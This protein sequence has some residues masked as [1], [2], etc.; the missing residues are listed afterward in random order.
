MKK[1]AWGIMIMFCV[2]SA[3]ADK[4]TRLTKKGGL[5]TSPGGTVEITVPAGAVTKTAKISILPDYLNE[6]E[7][8]AYVIETSKEIELSHPLIVT[9]YMPE[10]SSPY[11]TIY[12]NGV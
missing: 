2:S 9:F 3:Y 1:L 7:I 6:D 4:P 10:G 8:M 12:D 5:V 11:V